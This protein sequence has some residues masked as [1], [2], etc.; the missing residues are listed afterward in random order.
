MSDETMSQAQVAVVGDH[1]AVVCSEEATRLP[2]ESDDRDLRTQISTAVFAHE[3][4]CGKCDATAAYEQ[5][6][7]AYVRDVDAVEHMEKRAD[8]EQG[9]TEAMENGTERRDLVQEAQE[10]EEDVAPRSGPGEE[11]APTEESAHD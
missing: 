4:A 9:R 8:D 1:I 5:G 10:I 2:L 6:D 11:E 3:R 7:P